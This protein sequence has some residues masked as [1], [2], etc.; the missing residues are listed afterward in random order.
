MSG[1]GQAPYSKFT[2]VAR[3]SIVRNTNVTTHLQL[4]IYSNVLAC[5]SPAIPSVSQEGQLIYDSVSGS[6]FVSTLNTTGD[7]HWQAIEYVVC[8]D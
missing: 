8:G 2:S 4:P 6:V 7:L 5:V 1:A 3:N